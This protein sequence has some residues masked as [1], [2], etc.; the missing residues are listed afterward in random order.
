MQNRL[1]MKERFR[2]IVRDARNTSGMPFFHPCGWSSVNFPHCPR[3]RDW[4]VHQHQRIV[5]PEVNRI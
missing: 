3:E 4:L 2:V 5:E 1:A